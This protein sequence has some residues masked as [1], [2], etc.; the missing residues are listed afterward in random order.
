MASMGDDDYYYDDDY[1]YYDNFYQYYEEEEPELEQEVE[2][3]EDLGIN[4]L[5]TD[6]KEMMQNQSINIL[7]VK[8]DKHLS[9]I[10][11]KMLS[12]EC[13]RL[14]SGPTCP[15]DI[16][17]SW[18]VTFMTGLK[19]DVYEKS[20]VWRVLNDNEN[21]SYILQHRKGKRSTLF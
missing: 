1:N 16:F 8:N 4:N 7:D 10:Y 11:R 20:K 15:D 9:M 6:I 5:D 17:E 14:P 3:E 21:K 18:K 12:G 19:D 2:G 13:F